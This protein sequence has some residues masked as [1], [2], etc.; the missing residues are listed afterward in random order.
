MLALFITLAAPGL[1]QAPQ[2]A[3]QAPV[4]GPIPDDLQMARMVWST[5]V[6][7]DQAN[8]A[9][10]YSVLRDLSAPG[11]Q[12]ANDGAK[13]TQIFASLRGSGV[14]LTTTLL[15]PPTYRAK[16]ALVRADML[17]AQ[18]YFALR[19]TAINF[20]LYYQW[21]GDQWRLFGISIAPFQLVSPPSG[22]ADAPAQGKHKP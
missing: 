3:A 10:N 9:G 5:M 1:A 11:F 16:P 4:S 21:V 13:L 18:G 17:H 20:D 22:N 8:H 6:A 7:V 12:A 19:P 14:D 15:I 2:P